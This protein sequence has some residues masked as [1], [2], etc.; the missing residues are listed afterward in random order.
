MKLCNTLV[1]CITLTATLLI[2][3]CSSIEQES[4]AP[5]SKLD[6]ILITMTVSSSEGADHLGRH[7]GRYPANSV[8]IR[9]DSVPR[10]SQIEAEY[11]DLTLDSVPNQ[12]QK[13]FVKVWRFESYLLDCPRDRLPELATI[14]VF[15]SSGDER[16]EIV[17]LLN[18]Q[19]LSIMT[20]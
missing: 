17:F 15:I 5:R 20:G 11:H 18:G 10:N 4:F 2:V 1:S 6:E 19:Q 9:F 14:R 7:P 13:L 16:R 8:W 3:A 12:S